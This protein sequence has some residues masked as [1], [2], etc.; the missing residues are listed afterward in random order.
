MDNISNSSN[1]SSTTES[2]SAVGPIPRPDQI[3]IN[4]RDQTS[5]SPVRTGPT[6]EEVE[7]Y[8]RLY[9]WALPYPKHEDPDKKLDKKWGDNDDYKRYKDICYNYGIKHR[10]L[11]NY[12]NLREVY[13]KSYEELNKA[14]KAAYKWVSYNLEYYFEVCCHSF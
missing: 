2:S 11:V 12:N 7:E 9:G 13:G 3:V 6:E 1:S 5:D 10:R 8:I 4:P 14:E